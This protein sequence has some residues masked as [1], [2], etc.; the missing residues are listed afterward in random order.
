MIALVLVLACTVVGLS[1]ITTATIVGIP[2]SAK[3]MRCW[4]VHFAPVGSQTGSACKPTTTLGQPLAMR[5]RQLVGL[6]GFA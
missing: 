3:I 2:I 1:I 6:V 4:D 5:K